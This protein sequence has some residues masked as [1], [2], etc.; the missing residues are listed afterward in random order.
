MELITEYLIIIDKAESPSSY[1]LCDTKHEFN[2]LLQKSDPSIALKD[3][4]IIYKEVLNFVYE[5]ETGTVEGK[6]QRFFHLKITFND[7]EGYINDYYQLLRLI[8]TTSYS[9]TKQ[10]ITLKDDLSF[11]YANKAY[12]LIFNI[13]SL[14]RKLIY[15]FMLTLVG[16]KWR[17]EN[18][19]ESTK[20][21]IK[22]SKRKNP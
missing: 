11:Y 6:E 18:L 14:M 19:P 2:R 7:D 3:N 10:V 8:R 9:L 16:V 12:P 1:A 22:N 17:E 13:E 21:A 20:T 15:Y 4:Q 5:I